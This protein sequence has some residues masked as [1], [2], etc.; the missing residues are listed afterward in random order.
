MYYEDLLRSIQGIEP[1]TNDGNNNSENWDFGGQ[2]TGF[3]AFRF[4]DKKG[5]FYEVAVRFDMYKYWTMHIANLGVYPP[6]IR[7]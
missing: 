1:I 4:P 6:C 5:I 3:L 7:D 2:V